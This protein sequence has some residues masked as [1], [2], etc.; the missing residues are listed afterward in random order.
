MNLSVADYSVL[1]DV[2]RKAKQTSNEHFINQ[3]AHIA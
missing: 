2:L 1:L 3:I